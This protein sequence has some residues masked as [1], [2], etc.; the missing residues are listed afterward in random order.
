MEKRFAP[1]ICVFPNPPPRQAIF[2]TQAPFSATHS[3]F[4][5]S[6]TSFSCVEPLESRIAPAAVVFQSGSSGHKIG[7]IDYTDVDSA[8]EDAVFINTEADPSDPISALMG[9]GAPGVADTFYVKLTTNSLLK[10]FNQTG[11]Q[12]LISGDITGNAGITGTL[13]AFFVDKNL[14][15]EVQLNELTGLALGKNVQAI[16]SGSVDGDV[17][18]NFNDA[19]NKLG[20]AN[21]QPGQA[22]DLLLNPIT[23]L[24]VSG[25]VNGSVISGGQINK[26]SVG[27]VK[28]VLAGTAANGVSFDF[29]G[30]VT[31]GGDLLAVASPA[32]GIKGV[33]IL[34]TSIGTLNL[35]Q[36]GDGGAGAI[37]GALTNITLIAAQS[38]FL[39]Q[40]GDGGSGV[41]ARHNGGAGGLIS[42]VIINGLR[43]S[44][45][46]QSANSLIRIVAGD[47]GDN[48]LGSTGLGGVGGSLQNVFVG[49]ETVPG[50]TAPQQSLTALSDA[51]LIQGG[52]GGDG[53][54]AGAGGSIK[55]ASVFAS[56]SGAG[57]DIDLFGGV[58]G[59]TTVASTAAKAGAGGSVSGILVLNPGNSIEAE[60][61]KIVVAGGNAG[62][63]SVGGSGNAGGFVSAA[64]LIG[65]QTLLRGGDGSTGQRLGGNGGYVSAVI[66]QS[67]SQGVHPESVIIDAGHGGD[68]SAG[69]GG[70]GGRVFDLTVRN[71]DLREL[72]I[73]QTAGAGNGGMSQLGAGG[74]GGTVSMLDITESDT[75][76]A[77]A[78]QI[79]SGSGGTGGVGGGGRAGGAAGAISTVNISGVQ[80]D[81][82]VTGGEGG[83]ARSNAAGGKGAEING[84]S[85]VSYKQQD[86]NEVNATILGGVGGDGAG[87]GAGGIGGAVSNA[88]ITVGRS[89]S[90]LVGGVESALVDGGNIVV[91]AGIGGDS[92]GGTSGAGGAIV[93]S[94]FISYAGDVTASA[95]NAGSG[96]KAATGGRIDNLAVQVGR[97]VSISS[98]NGGGGGSGGDILH[99][100]FVRAEE[101]LNVIGS[102]IAAAG[103]APL[104]AISLLAG[105]GSGAGKLA[106][107]GGSIID[108][109]GYV[110]IA[111]AT[112]FTAGN[113]AAVAAKAGNGGSISGIGLLGGGGAGAVVRISAGNAVDSS[114]AKIGGAGGDVIDV[115]LGVNIFN[116]A[117][118]ADPENA[119]ALDPL[120]VIQHVSAGDGGGTGLASGKGGR[121]GDVRALN[122]H[123]DIGIRSG[124]GFGFDTMGG[125]FA[126]SG[127]LNTSITHTATTLEARD[128]QSGSVLQVTADAIAAIV[129]GK[130]QAGDILTVRN[131]AARVDDIILNG[132]NV[133]TRV[134]A[135]GTFL[136]FN[137]ANLIGGVVNPSDAGA[138]YNSPGTPPVLHPHAN[139]FDAIN[140]EFIDTN[141]DG[142]FGLGDTLTAKTDGFIAALS[143]I[144]NAANVRPEAVLTSIGGV[145]TFVDLNNTNGQLVQP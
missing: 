12:P 35:M 129:A 46:D 92:T 34:N 85:F 58:G 22:H 33:S 53:R 94:S 27:S 44:E 62:S 60:A 98:G 19:L 72:L 116:K 68:A 70:S 125:I 91:T 11:F 135:N 9:I 76:N 21:D 139:T 6:V 17:V 87:T 16:I 1:V 108:V 50:K 74:V 130:P 57:N 96:V 89:V 128:G 48:F 42:G 64:N 39:L 32:P 7:E 103:P 102:I 137:T 118:P 123:E 141:P 45:V 15:N 54:I 131:L 26:L 81:L 120:T 63:A 43:A 79:R 5:K 143:F 101:E 78:A 18:S 8:A 37:G 61:S 82:T 90:V 31:G 99:A 3:A 144:N 20:G 119:L 23:S 93:N 51:V 105:A 138:A 14:D 65:S 110:G 28:Q 13:I 113:G 121:G 100:G 71:G 134:D 67:S 75:G 36:A 47:G 38:G 83:L 117:N 126:G 55:S 95:A 30:A 104:G 41:A 69:R 84:L 56:P 124:V 86:G 59:A 115:G 40:S 112:T 88:S 140:G 80:L 136:N 49:Y 114:S 122:T 25:N 4:M 133:A 77:G 132:L 106:G 107:N 111:G 109:S 142:V 10:V 29:N 52:L 127:G 2:F 73:N 97:N 66:V 145:V 24:V